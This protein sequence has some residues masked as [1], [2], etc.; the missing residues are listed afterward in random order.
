MRL[1]TSRGIGEYVANEAHTAIYGRLYRAD[2]TRR[3][4]LIFTG[5]AGDDLDFLTADASGKQL[6]P[7]LAD[8]GVVCAS[9]AYG[10]AAQWGNDTS[11]T[12]IGQLFSLVQTR[13]GT[14]TDK[15]VG[16]GV[17]KG[18]TSMLNY[19]RNNPTKVAALY[20]IAPAV[21]VSAIYN[22][23]RGGLAASISAAYGGNWASAAATHDPALNTAAHASQ[24]IPMKLMYG[25][26]DTTCL[27]SE[28]TSFASATGAQATQVGAGLTHLTTAPAID[29]ADTLQ[30]VSRYI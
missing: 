12:R 30:F 15:F 29:P 21:N 10:G 11:Q 1:C 13:F 19:A 23:D 20:L 22:G 7:T 9:A 3:P 8:N 18:A 14:K 25:G 16:I 6:A 27:S 17:S 28:V 24:G 5:G 4:V 2:V 26:S